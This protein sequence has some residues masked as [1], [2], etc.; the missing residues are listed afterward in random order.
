MNDIVPATLHDL[1]FL[2]LFL[3]ADPIVKGVMI[4]LV[5]AS[6]GCWTIMV[7][8][9]LRFRNAR[10]QARSFETVARSTERLHPQ[11]AGTTGRIVAAGQDAWRD[12]DPSESR[13]ERRERIERA[14][15]AALSADMRQL[16]VGLPFLATIG[17][18]A[19]FI[20]LFGT[21]WGIM[22]AFS[23]IAASQDTS[24]AVVAPGIAEALFATAIGLVA[25]IP[26]VIAYN[27][28]TTDLGRLQQSFTAGITALGDRLARDRKPHLRA[29]AAE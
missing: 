3:Q 20:G 29:E 15:R 14:M 19:P 8:K 12:Q 22:N 17:S 16:Q 23:A 18:A 9:L 7:E 4:L 5:L 6:L 27:K 13:A 25:A 1:S 2:G 10:H 26:A 28:L 21:V 24:L 11:P